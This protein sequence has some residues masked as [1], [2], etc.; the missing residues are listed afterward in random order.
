LTLGVSIATATL[1]LLS[2]AAAIRAI[3]LIAESV[4]DEKS[5]SSLMNQ[6]ARG[7]AIVMLMIAALANWASIQD[8]SLRFTSNATSA[9]ATG[10]GLE[11]PQIYTT[12]EAPPQ[13]MARQL[14]ANILLSSTDSLTTLVFRVYRFYQVRTMVAGLAQTTQQPIPPDVDIDVWID[15]QILELQSQQDSRSRWD[16]VMGFSNGFYTAL[17]GFLM[18]GLAVISAGIFA[19]VALYHLI[20]SLLVILVALGLGPIAIAIAPVQSTFIRN[21]GATLI[22]AGLQFAFVANLTTLLTVV[23][24]NVAANM[25][26]SGS[27]SSGVVAGV[28]ERAASTFLMPLLCIVF[29][30]LIPKVLSTI[31]EIFSGGKASSMG[32][33][34]KAAAAAAGVSRIMKMTA[35]AKTGGATAVAGAAAGAASKAAAGGG[36]LP[37]P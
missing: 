24:N 34:L 9:I 7:G 21:L 36:R 19:V 3:L 6:L 30:L 22:A 17:T 32:G 27:L 20:G 11:R 37:K 26:S 25:L 23:I 13:M 16:Q 10:M 5:T 15:Q 29:A 1:I 18:L 4:L 14:S 33:V 8:W 28:F 2:L 31:T 35:A 12:P